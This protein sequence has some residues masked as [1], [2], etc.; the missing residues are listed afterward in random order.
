VQRG[1]DRSVHAAGV[2]ATGS[3]AKPGVDEHMRAASV[4]KA[5]SAAAALALV[6]DGVISLDDTIAERLPD[7]PKEW[8]AVTLH[9]LL[10][11]TSGLPNYTQ[12]PGFA[13]AVGAS[14]GEAVSPAELLGFVADEPLVFRPGTRYT[15][16]NSDNVA[17]DLVMESGHRQGLRRRARRAGLRTARTGRDV[18]AG[19]DFIR[20]YVAG[21]LFGDEVREEQQR[22]FIPAGGS[23]PSGPGENSAS[24]SLFR[25]ETECE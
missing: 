3:D 6:G 2:S 10:D 18:A 5:F 4:S 1:S 17:V 9:Q 23:D 16:S 24:M 14:P 25:Y 19:D 13:E 21:E 11:H 20:G 22:L 12:S 8:G 15:Y 7:L